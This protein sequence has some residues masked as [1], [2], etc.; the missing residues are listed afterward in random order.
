MGELSD[1]SS[2]KGRRSCLRCKTCAKRHGFNL[3]SLCWRC[4]KRPRRRLCRKRTARASGLGVWASHPQR[5]IRL[6][7]VDFCVD[8]VAADVII[9]LNSRG[10]ITLSSCQ[11]DSHLP[12]TLTFGVKEYAWKAC[13]LLGVGSVRQR[14]HHSHET[15]ANVDFWDVII[16]SRL[17]GELAAQARGQTYA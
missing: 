2:V 10:M 17:W 3:A 15:G 12:G 6:G 5:H 14:S 11:G 1:D 16:P 4:R 9:W 7:A 13:E 8:E